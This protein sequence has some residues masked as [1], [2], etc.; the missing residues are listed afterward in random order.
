M[1]GFDWKAM[2][3]ITALFVAGSVNAATLYTA[4][5]TIAGSDEL[6]CS[7]ANVGKASSPKTVRVD[8]ISTAGFS[9]SST[10]DV[11]LGSGSSVQASSSI[12][13]FTPSYCM[14]TVSGAR[15]S[16][17][18]QGC[19]THLNGSCTAISPAQ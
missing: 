12:N 6:I 11:S 1:K 16:Y 17:R 15:K 8:V 5:T 4:P 2:L 7:L 3:A 14:F 10:G 18:A 13:L 19:I 9:V